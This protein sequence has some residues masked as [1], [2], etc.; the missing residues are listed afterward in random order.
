MF[1]PIFGSE[2]V[3]YMGL[4]SYSKP[5]QAALFSLLVELDTGKVYYWNGTTWA[6]FGA[7]A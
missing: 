2:S 1:I 7:E 3:Q 6:L 5:E 4:S